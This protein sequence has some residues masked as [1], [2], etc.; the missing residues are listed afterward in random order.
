MP[1]KTPKYYKKTK[2]PVEIMNV[3]EETKKKI[4]S[5]KISRVLKIAGQFA[6]VLFLILGTLE[7]ISAFEA[8]V[9]NVT[10]RICN[11]VETRT[12]G[13][14]KNHIDI[15]IDI[16]PQYL[17]VYPP[18]DEE[19]WVPEA[20]DTFARIEQIFEDA[21]AKEMAD[22]LRAQLLAMKFNVEYFPGTGD[23]EF[24]Y[25]GTTITI[26]EIID[27]ADAMLRQDPLPG[28]EI[29]RKMKDLLESLNSE[30]KLTHCS[31]P[32]E[33]FSFFGADENLIAQLIS[34]VF[35]YEIAIEIEPLP[36][37]IAEQ[38]QSC[39]TGLLGVCS[40]GIQ[41]CSSEGL[42]SECVETEYIV[43]E[44]CDDGLDNDCNG[45]IDC[46]D[47]TCAED[48]AC[49]SDFVLEP[50]T[51]T[52]C[53]FEAQQSCSTALLGICAV[54]T[55][56]CNQEGFWG[57]CLQDNASTTEVCDNQ[58]DDD[59]NGLVDCEDESCVED[60]ACQPEPEPESCGDNIING[61]E[62]CDQGE[63]NGVECVSEYGSSC[64]YCSIE[65]AT[66][67]VVG[68]FCGDNNL[69]EN[70]ECDDG[71]NINEDGCSDTCLIEQEPELPPEE[72]NGNATTTE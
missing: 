52:E 36:E 49:Q 5:S 55:Q 12:I 3:L 60:Q 43:S 68:A 48:S 69:D 40:A 35:S 44:I 47:E 23:F 67:E 59:C 61:E 29:L 9:I 25:D 7:S 27:I 45:L 62:Q 56:T 33:G 41:T 70:E 21:N 4:N 24:E 37:C 16:L 19:L 58:L 46:E 31:G 42:W 11:Y 34:S 54:G 39:D 2:I 22:M 53:E 30:H 15:Y 57:E 66:V 50:E 65:C 8:H 26:Y 6:F 71:N 32:N 18:P 14:W 10:A 63:S 13:F 64:S 1:K 20:N 28:R 51:A 38:I 17:G 72:P